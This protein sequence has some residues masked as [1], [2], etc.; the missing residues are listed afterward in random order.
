[1]RQI[2]KRFPGV[3]ANDHVDFSVAAG[4]VHVL[5]GENG[6][7]KST[8]MQILYGFLRMDEGEILIGGKSVR[9]DSPKTA[10]ALGIG[11][12]HQDFTLADSLTVVENTILGL[13][14]SF[15]PV[16]RIRRASERL[17]L[18]SSRYG[19]AVDP[20]AVVGTLP[21]GVRQRVEILKLLYRDAKVL[22][23]DEPTAVLTS[24]EKDRLFSVLR[25]L[26]AEGHSILLITHKLHEIMELADRV[27]VMR[28]GRAVVTVD[29]R[30]TNEA[31]LSQLMFGREMNLRVEKES[32][33]PGLVRLSI[34]DLRVR[35]DVGQESVRGISLDVHEGEIVGIAGVEGNG[36]A[37][38]AQAILRLRP[39]QGGE[40]NLPLSTKAEG[41]GNSISYV[42]ADRRFVGSV[43]VM[44]IADNSVLGS[45]WERMRGPFMDHTAKRLHAR[46][47][48]RRFGVRCATLE[49]SAEQLSGGNL[50][51][52]IL[53][54]EILRDAKVMVVEQPTR[55]LDAG[56]VTTIW[57]ELL[58]ERKKG[59]AILLISA[60]LEELLSL[61]DRIA[62]IFEGRIVGIVEGAV[63]TMETIGRLMAGS[64]PDL[65][66]EADSHA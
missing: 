45:Q 48:V 2:V 25:S 62:V 54:R 11:M 64:V 23:L 33:I 8:L 4:E 14:Q 52:L 19:L 63:A 31:E 24:P 38:M 22:I 65:A 21:I 29:T 53:G 26:R 32:N 51:K 37:E 47:L 57:K 6:A 42:P 15:G 66:T 34:R 60:E 13:K 1:M 18:L 43:A 28:D 36:Q 30:H 16:L 44:S 9:I 55:G 5:L 10:I 27:T 20:S 35:G 59:T 61:C 50:Q 58:R 41:R 39:I 40:I 49:T 3:L 46:E 17:R 7:G 12:L 56:A